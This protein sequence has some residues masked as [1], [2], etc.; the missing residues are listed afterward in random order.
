MS[1]HTHPHKHTGC[2]CPCDQEEK[3]GKKKITN[4]WSYQITYIITLQRLNTGKKQN[5]F[6]FKEWLFDTLFKE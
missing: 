5:H 4:H 2:T 3:E 1:M 6:D